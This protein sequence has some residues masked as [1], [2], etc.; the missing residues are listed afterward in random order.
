MDSSPTK[1]KIFSLQ[2]SVGRVGKVAQ[3]PACLILNIPFGQYK[4][5]AKVDDFCVKG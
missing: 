1:Q 4:S 3:V 2:D 5:E